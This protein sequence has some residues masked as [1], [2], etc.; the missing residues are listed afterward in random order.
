[1]VKQ[2][3]HG[4]NFCVNVSECAVD[5][6]LIIMLRCVKWIQSTSIDILG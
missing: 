2:V 4:R 5:R 3:F 1:M 6:L